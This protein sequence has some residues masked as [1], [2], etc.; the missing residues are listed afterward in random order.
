MVTR[1][2]S[3]SSPIEL[4]PGNKGGEEMKMLLIVLLVLVPLLTAQV[5]LFSDDFS[6]SNAE[7]D[8]VVVTSLPLAL[9]QS[10]WAGIKSIF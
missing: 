2:S 1:S 4:P 6:E 10:T 3:L 5:V 9:H 7:L 8:N